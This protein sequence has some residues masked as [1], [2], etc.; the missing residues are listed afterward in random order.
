MGSRYVNI[1]TAD[2]IRDL[3]TMTE[4]K[5]NT[6]VIAATLSERY[7]V[8]ITRNMIIG[9]ARRIGIALNSNKCGAPKGT[10]RVAKADKDKLV[11]FRAVYKPREYVPA[12][13]PLRV[14]FMELRRDQCKEV[15]GTGGDALAI[16]CGHPTDGG[17]WCPSCRDRNTQ[18]RAA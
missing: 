10:R 7:G 4:D 1:W 12:I 16:Y 17:P 18:E 14:P 8:R 2:I 6:R 3:M 9:K 5:Q 11:K 13:E 15:V